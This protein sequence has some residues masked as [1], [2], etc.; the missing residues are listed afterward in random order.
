MDSSSQRDV[1]SAPVSP[2]YHTLWYL[3]DTLKHGGAW[4]GTWCKGECWITLKLAYTLPTQKA[5]MGANGVERSRVWDIR[6]IGVIIVRTFLPLVL[7]LFNCCSPLWV[8][9]WTSDIPQITTDLVT[10]TDS[11]KVYILWFLFVRLLRSH[12]TASGGTASTSP[13]LLPSQMRLCYYSTCIRNY[14]YSP[15]Q[16]QTPLPHSPPSLTSLLTLR[17][18]QTPSPPESAPI[19][20]ALHQSHPVSRL[21]SSSTPSPYPWHPRCSRSYWKPTLWSTQLVSQSGCCDNSSYPAALSVRGPIGSWRRGIAGGLFFC[22]PWLPSRTTP[23][24][25]PPQ[26]RYLSLLGHPDL[27]SPPPPFSV[28]F[29]SVTKVCEKWEWELQ[30]H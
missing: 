5:G 26:Q 29:R 24:S 28:S 18:L 27:L 9:L 16:I 3:P 20:W 30:Y 2:K 15:T 22:F 12:F 1:W 19:Q 10:V 6:Y 17:E 25:V 13:I 23:S 11:L 21:I 4:L 8:S 7:S 14:S